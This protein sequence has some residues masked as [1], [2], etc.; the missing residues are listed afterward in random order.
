MS[1]ISD[2]CLVRNTR[3]TRWISSQLLR[4]LYT[5]I[6]G[7]CFAHCTGQ[8]TGLTGIYLVAWPISWLSIVRISI[9]LPLNVHLYR[10][11]Y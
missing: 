1:P 4:T 8:D 9:Y 7:C 10:I 11:C 2:L 6:L 3:W 5:V